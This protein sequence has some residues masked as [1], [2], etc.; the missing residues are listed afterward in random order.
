MTSNPTLDGSNVDQ[1]G[2]DNVYLPTFG[3]ETSESDIHE[4]GQLPQK[5][6]G[7]AEAQVELDTM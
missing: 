6:K 3:K 4:G 2:P 7:G 1:P 5:R